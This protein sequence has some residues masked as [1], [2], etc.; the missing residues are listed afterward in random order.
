MK[1]LVT[2]GAGYIGSHVV[3]QLG[4]AGFS[5]I[6]YDNMST[7]HKEAVLYG[8]L[9]IG[10]LANRTTLSELFAKY[11]FDAVLHFA[12]DI[13]VPESIEKP[14]Q[15][16][17]N[18]T[19]N[20]LA[21]LTQCEK[22]DIRYFI[23]SSTA[24]VYGSQS[25]DPVN[26]NFPLK[27]ESPYGTS[28]IM[29]EQI[30]R[31]FAKASGLRYVILRYFNVA[32]ADPDSRIGQFG[33]HTSHLIKKAC[34]TAAG[35]HPKISIYGTDYDTPDGTCI[36]DYI[37]VED[38]ADAHILSLKYLADSN[39]NNKN[40]IIL[41]CGYGHG[42]SVRKVLNTAREVTKINFKIEETQRRQG[43]SPIVI[44]DSTL[45]QKTLGWQPNYDNLYEIIDSAW[46]WEKRLN[47]SF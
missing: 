10:D 26:E 4:E 46:R 38:L 40:S 28:K 3:K 35:L 25:S 45:I 22:Y 6:V 29:A 18:N 44:A 32:G 17:A 24:S 20:T 43:D 19:C 8:E 14:L 33:N 7:G 2:G 23:F 27:P 9:V 16:Y 31:D 5:T 15:Y 11:E 30:I 34:R 41:N 21:L 47:R 39:R 1:I 37:H 36:R 42:Y 12:A 13:S